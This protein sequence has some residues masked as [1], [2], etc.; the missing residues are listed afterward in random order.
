MSYNCCTHGACKIIDCMSHFSFNIAG[1]DAR[2]TGAG[3]FI[4]AASLKYQGLNEDEKRK[5]TESSEV[6]KE[7]TIT[8]QKK[9]GA[10]IFKKIQKQVQN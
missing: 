7:L 2:K 3:S 6:T 1:K 8:D 4:K 9:A 5:L 10:K